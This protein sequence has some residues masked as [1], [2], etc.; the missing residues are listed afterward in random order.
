M[1][2]GSEVAVGAAVGEVDSVSLLLFVVLQ[3][4]RRQIGRMKASA[5]R[6]TAV[7]DIW[8]VSICFGVGERQDMNG[9]WGTPIE[10]VNSIV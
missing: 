9:L 7:A 5:N 4:T 10:R 3:A 1:A 6:C 8:R 2:I